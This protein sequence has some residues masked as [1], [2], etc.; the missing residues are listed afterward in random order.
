[1]EVQNETAR[2]HRNDRRRGRRAWPRSIRAQQSTAPTVDSG[3]V[4]RPALTLKGFTTEGVPAALFSPDGTQ[5]VTVSGDNVAQFWNA[6]TGAAL[7]ELKDVTSAAFSP[8]GSLLVTIASWETTATVWNVK[9]G[10]KL[11]SLVGHTLSL[12]YAEFSPDGAYV[13]TASDDATARI[14]DVKTGT[15]ITTLTKPSINVGVTI[16]RY[17]SDGNRIVTIVL[18]TLWLWNT[19]TGG[20]LAELSGHSKDAWSVNSAAFSHDGSRIVSASDDKTA[21]LWDGKTGVALATLVGHTAPV[22]DAELSPDNSRVVTASEDKTARLWDG[23]TGAPVAT[24]A[25]DTAT[26]N[27][28]EFSPD[29]TCIVTAAGD[30]QYLSSTS[31]RIWIPFGSPYFD[32]QLGGYTARLWDGKTGA[33]LA[34][35]VGHLYTV[36]SAHFSQDGKR[37][38]TASDDNTA[39]VWQVS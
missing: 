37:V 13:V 25:G 24:L 1:M 34:N 26:V 32:P 27:S 5:I 3:K 29:G 9:T 7:V 35:L 23:K 10:A 28:A 22:R 18:E 21:R 20:L 16:A 4:I 31:S 2:V 6:S 17:S 36:N 39:C 14:W 30:P 38:L 11:V 33:A 19:K 8:D 15:C 12:N